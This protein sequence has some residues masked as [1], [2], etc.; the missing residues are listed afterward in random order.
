MRVIAGKLRGR[1]LKGPEGRALRPTSDRLRE[2]IFNILAHGDSDGLAGAT[3]ADIFAGSGALGIEALSRG[4]KAVTF[5]ESDPIARQIIRTNLAALKVAESAELLACPADQ[6][7]ARTRPFNLILLDP[8]Y[9]KDLL[10]P[11]L[12]RL[13]AAGWLGQETKVVIETQYP[14]PAAL[15]PPLKVTDRRR[16][17]RSEILFVAV[18][19]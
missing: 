8:P 5:V 18:E 6:V 17:A 16:Q 10:M 15:P 4:A 12:D 1:H 11:A 19:K 3:V 2:R 9:G 14:G 13:L 7:P